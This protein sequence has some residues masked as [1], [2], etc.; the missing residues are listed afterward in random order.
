MSDFIG[1]AHAGSPYISAY[2]LSG[3]GIGT[4]FS[5]PSTLPPNTGIAI[6][7]TTKGDAVGIGHADS[8]YISVYKWSRLG[9]GTKFSNPS[10][11]P[12]S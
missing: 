4:K 12:R 10:S 5:N 11:P 7:F 8:P 2:P 9:F 3:S 1:I 6:A